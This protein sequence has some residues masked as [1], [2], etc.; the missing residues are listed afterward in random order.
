MGMNFELARS[1]MVSQQVR[2]WD[3]LDDKVLSVLGELPRE[4]FV[5]Q[6]YRQLAYSDTAIPLNETEFMMKPVVEGR[7]L[8][9]LDLVG[10]EDVLEIGTGSGYFAACLSKLACRVC[11]VEI[12]DKLAASARTQLASL[13]LDSI[14]VETGDAFSDW[15]TDRQFDVIVLSGAVEKLPSRLTAWLKPGGRV[16]AAVGQSPN[17]QV[18]I[19]TAQGNSLVSQSS[20]FETDLPY[21]KGGQQPASFEF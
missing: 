5:P 3:V 14:E 6:R 15:S 1:N 17:M 13:E 21:L 12:D 8:Q 11:S 10:D 16:I 19:A 20:M 4:E 18:V 7:F 2:T 9:A